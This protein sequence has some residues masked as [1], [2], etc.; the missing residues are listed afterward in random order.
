MN[1]NKFLLATTLAVL[2]FQLLFSVYYSS[3]IIKYNQIYTRLEKKYSD[4]K[5]QNQKLEFNYINQ[6]HLHEKLPN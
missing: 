3:Q 6:Y 5:W 2:T 4:L 1:L